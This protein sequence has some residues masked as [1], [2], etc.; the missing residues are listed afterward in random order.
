ML[1]KWQRKKRSSSLRGQI[2]ALRFVLSVRQH[3]DLRLQPMGQ[4]DDQH[5]VGILEAGTAVPEYVPADSTSVTLTLK[6]TPVP[7]GYERAID[8][9]EFDL[10]CCIATDNTTLMSVEDTTD[11]CGFFSTWAA[12]G[13][14]QGRRDN[15]SRT[16]ASSLEETT[17]TWA[18]G[19]PEGA[20]R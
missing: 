4:S 20:Q 8:H 6:R 17:Q 16:L 3:R 2:S 10:R 15:G 11:S 7:D 18:L 1:Q 5:L 19:R 9:F 13:N 12:T 14:S